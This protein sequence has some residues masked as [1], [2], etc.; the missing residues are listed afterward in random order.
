LYHTVDDRDQNDEAGVQQLRRI[1]LPESLA[2]LVT[3]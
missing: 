1:E 2:L 3:R